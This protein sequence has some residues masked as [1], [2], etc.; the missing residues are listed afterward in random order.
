MIAPER[1]LLGMERGRRSKRAE[2]LRLRTLGVC[3]LENSVIPVTTHHESTTLLL[4]TSLNSIKRSVPNS[5]IAYVYV[6]V[7]KYDLPGLKHCGPPDNEV[8]IDAPL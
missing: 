2:L 8:D 7:D 3:V 5:D 1:L 4:S 6:V